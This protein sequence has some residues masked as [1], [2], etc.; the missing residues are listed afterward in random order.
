MK[1]ILGE[2]KRE[3]NSNI[4][5]VDYFSTPFSTM[6]RLS[7]QKNSKVTVNLNNIIGQKDIANIYGILYPREREYTFFQGYMKHSPKYVTFIQYIKLEINTRKKHKPFKNIWKLNSVHL[8]IQW[9]KGSIK[10]KS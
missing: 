6:N 1:K 9:I 8:K 3:I 7:R 4:M 10:R 2:L 5:I